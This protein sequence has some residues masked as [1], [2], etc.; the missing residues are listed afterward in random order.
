MKLRDAGTWLRDHRTDP[1]VW[2]EI[3]Q[4]GKTV[5][6]GTL[7]WWVAAPLLHL[8]QPFLAPWSAL[9]VVH[10][11]VY[12]TFAGERSRPAARSRACCSRGR[13]ATCSASTRWR[14]R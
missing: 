3:T 6:A 12:R 14:S 5:L 1:I 4:V 9:L 8:P 13:S 2:T 11:T 7:A 10:A